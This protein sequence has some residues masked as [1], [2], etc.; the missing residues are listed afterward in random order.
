MEKHAAYGVYFIF[1]AWSGNSNG[2]A[3][4]QMRQDAVIGCWLGT[5]VR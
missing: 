5:L 2:K 1:K 4:A 3:A